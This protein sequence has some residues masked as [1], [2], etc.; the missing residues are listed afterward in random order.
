MWSSLLGRM[1]NSVRSLRMPPNPSVEETST[2][3]LPLLAATPH[4]R[5]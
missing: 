2:S 3:M 1:A 5:R 4:V